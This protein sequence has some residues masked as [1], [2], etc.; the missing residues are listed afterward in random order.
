MHQEIFGDSPSRQTATDCHKEAWNEWR[1]RLRQ[2][3]RLYPD[4]TCRVEA[5]WR[6][7]LGGQLEAA[8]RPSGRAGIL[9]L[10][11]GWRIC[12]HGALLSSRQPAPAYSATHWALPVTPV[13]ESCW[14]LSGASH[15]LLNDHGFISQFN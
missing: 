11:S 7:A 4:Q 9:G 13:C 6:L 8:G 15:V 12:C 10:L 1:T 14:R 2:W 5:D 3:R